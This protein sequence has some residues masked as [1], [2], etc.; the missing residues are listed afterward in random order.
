MFVCNLEFIPRY[1]WSEAATLRQLAVLIYVFPVSYPRPASLAATQGLPCR[2][3]RA[4]LTV[5][6]R[7]TFNQGTRKSLEG[8]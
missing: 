7:G 1:M 5:M 8:L 6:V 2:P 4:N 3:S